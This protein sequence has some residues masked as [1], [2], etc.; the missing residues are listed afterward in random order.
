MTPAAFRA[1]LDR[2]L[3]TGRARNE[4]ECARL[5]G[6]RE[7]TRYKA[8]GGDYRLAL[9]CGALLAGIGPFEG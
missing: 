6:V 4:T 1:W 9:S 7:V 8:R 5:L 2:M 3:E